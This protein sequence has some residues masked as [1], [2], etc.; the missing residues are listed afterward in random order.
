VEEGL[1]FGRVTLQGANI[2]VR[3]HERAAPVVPHL[4]DAAE[5]VED[6]ALMG[7]RVAADPVVRQLFIEGSECTL[8]DSPIESLRE[9]SGFFHGHGPNIPSVFAIAAKP[10][11]QRTKPSLGARWAVAQRGLAVHND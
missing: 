4:A 9:W 7:A 3:H 2:A 5:T 11:I 6:Q 1:F 10:R 8:R